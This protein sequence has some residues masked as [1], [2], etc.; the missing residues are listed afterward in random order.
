[1]IRVIYHRFSIIIIPTVKYHNL[2]LILR[3]LGIINTMYITC[4]TYMLLCN[5]NAN[6]MHTLLV[7]LVILMYYYVKYSSDRAA[8]GGGLRAPRRGP[9]PGPPQRAREW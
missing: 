3:S 7:L 1:M 8:L 6:T 2:I 9:L 5:I 4:N